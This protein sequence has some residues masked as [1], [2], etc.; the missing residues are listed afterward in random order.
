MKEGE[1]PLIL[2]NTKVWMD[3]TDL[4][5]ALQFKAAKANCT[6][7]EVSD[8]M[9]SNEYVYIICQ[10]PRTARVI[11][12]VDNRDRVDVAT[13]TGPVTTPWLALP[14]MGKL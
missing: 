6:W 1:G 5:S 2:D 13:N 10:D 3:P 4:E 9:N 11:T 14:G 8:K 7:C 12:I